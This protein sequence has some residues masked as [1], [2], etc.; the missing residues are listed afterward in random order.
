MA[1]KRE[2]GLCTLC[3]TALGVED[4]DKPAGVPC[5]HLTPGGC[6]IYE[7]RPEQCRRFECDW[8][9]GNGDRDLRP[10]R[11]GAVITSSEIGMNF[12]VLPEKHDRWQ[13]SRKLRRMVEKLVEA[14]F[15]VFVVSGETDRTVYTGDQKV[16]DQITELTGGQ[17]EITVKEGI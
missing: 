4:L 7:D 2:C 10:D 12:H 9:R 14:G 13:R 16:L 17:Y 1:R 3:C 6:G 11:I 8:L 5:V 15:S